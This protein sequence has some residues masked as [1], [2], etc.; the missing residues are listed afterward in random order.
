MKMVPVASRSIAAIGYE[1]GAL[2]I[3]FRNGSLYEYR[4]VPAQVVQALLCSA[5][6][7]SF[8]ARF[9]KGRWPSIRLA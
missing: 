5:S 6:K 1:N 4:G 2:R 8:Y 9:I 3:S 7:G